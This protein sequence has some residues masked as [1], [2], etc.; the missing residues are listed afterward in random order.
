MKTK[1]DRMDKTLDGDPLDVRAMAWGRRSALLDLGT[2]AAAS[3]L[4]A[5][6]SARYW[7][8]IREPPVRRWRLPPERFAALVVDKVFTFKGVPY[9]APTGGAM[10]FMPP[11]KA[12]AV[13]GRD[14]HRRVGPGSAAGPAHRN[15]RSCGDDSDDRDQRRLPA[16]E[17]VDDRLERQAA[18]DGMA[19]RR[20][21]HQRIGQ[22][23]D[24]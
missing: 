6:K 4:W 14:G 3:V 16:P 8:P 10:R 24:V 5:A 1:R 13:D 17:R 7:L 23:H 11:A 12:A 2:A 21:I 9:G 15:S 19:A 18:G 22:L 20:R